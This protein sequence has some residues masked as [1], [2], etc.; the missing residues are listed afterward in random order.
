MAVLK[1]AGNAMRR[2]DFIKAI[3]R[4]ATAWPLAADAQQTE[5]TRRVVLLRALMEMIRKD[6]DE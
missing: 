3:T 6:R 1:P 5:R 4:S 2:R